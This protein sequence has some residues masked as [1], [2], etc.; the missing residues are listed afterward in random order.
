MG[1]LE[2][3][4]DTASTEFVSFKANIKAWMAGVVGV[5]DNAVELPN[6][7]LRF[8]ARARRMRA[9]KLATG[10]MSVEATFEIKPPSGV[11]GAAAVNAESVAASLLRSI[12]NPSNSSEF[13]TSDLISIASVGECGNGACENGEICEDGEDAALCCLADCPLVRKSE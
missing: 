2:K 7:G 8:V 4:Q 5:P 13:V 12:T 11:A 1:D 10:D 6:N 3:L 9:R